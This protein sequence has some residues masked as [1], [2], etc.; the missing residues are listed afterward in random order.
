MGSL[1]KEKK[2]VVETVPNPDEITRK[3]KSQEFYKELDTYRNRG[4][5]LPVFLLIIVTAVLIAFVSW[6]LK[7]SS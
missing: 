3:E 7:Q 4:G 1:I 5:W 2:E 6:Y